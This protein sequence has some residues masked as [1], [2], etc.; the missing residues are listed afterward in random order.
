MNSNCAIMEICY[1]YL[2]PILLYVIFSVV[3]AFLV[4]INR[5]ITIRERGC[6]LPPSVP[7]LDPIFGLDIVLQVLSSFRER[8][9]N[10]SF[11]EQFDRFGR[12]FQS[13]VY[14]NTKLFTI[15]PKNLQ[16]VFSTDFESWG[17]QPLRLFF[18]GPFIGKGIMTTD[19]PFWEH[20]R[21]LMRPTFSRLQIGN[22]SA[23]SDHVDRL[24]NLIP[25]DGSIVDLQVLFASLALDSSTELLF[26]QSTGS[27]APTMAADAKAFLAAYNHGQ[28]GV[29]KRMQLPQW[30]FL[31][32][33]KRFWRSCAVAREFVDKY[34]EK[35][36][37][38]GGDVEKKADRLVLAQELAKQSRNRD[39]IRNQLLNVFLPAHDATSVALTNVFFNLARNPGVYAKLRQEILALNDAGLTFE[40]LKSLKYLQNVMNETFRLNPAIGQMNRVALHDTMLPTGGG[41]EGTSP[42][43]VRKGSVL[44]TSFYALHRLPHIYGLDADVFCP[45][46]WQTLRPVPWSYMP[47]GGGPRIC[48]GQQLS[49]TEVGYTTAR[50]V[51]H[52]QRIENAD[53]ILEFVEQWKITT[54][55]K[56]GA[57]VR[58]FLE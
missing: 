56:N 38:V 40:R 35:A 15:E 37:S 58:L 22:L 25:K 50:I 3:R 41:F 53:P 31:T 10:I 27:L 57:K 14:G 51:R 32:R 29:G 39:N 34:V 46:R 19:G 47:F 1:P 33:D 12:T 11:K 17:V 36:L 2:I 52:F 21:A 16:S 43:F 23:Y 26:G 5:R 44:T 54:S 30:N 49:L 48:I 7:Q 28:A 55:S 20:S 42:V 24:I 45:E 4:R 18:F 8:R 9:R 13:H 6:K